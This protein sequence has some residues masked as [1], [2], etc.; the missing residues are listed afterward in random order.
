MKCSIQ[1]IIFFGNDEYDLV[2]F[3]FLLLD[4]AFGLSMARLTDDVD[5]SDP[6]PYFRLINAKKIQY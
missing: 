1:F 4:D 3:D 6:I 5:I 2:Y